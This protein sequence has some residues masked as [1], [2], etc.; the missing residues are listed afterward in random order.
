MPRRRSRPF[1][2][3]AAPRLG[4]SLLLLLACLSISAPASAQCIANPEE[5]Y[6]PP[7]TAGEN[8]Y[9]IV[10]D[11]ALDHLAGIDGAEF[12]YATTIA[13]DTWNEQ[14]KAGWF[15]LVGLSLQEDPL[16]VSVACPGRPNIVRAIAEAEE[17]E[18]GVTA[19]AYPRWWDGDKYTRWEIVIFTDWLNPTTLQV[20]PKVRHAGEASTGSLDVVSELIHEFGHALWL[21]HLRGGRPRPSSACRAARQEPASQT[22]PAAHSRSRRQRFG[23][24]DC[25]GVRRHLAYIGSTWRSMKGVNSVG[26]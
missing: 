4:V 8:E 11:A 21:G 6:R 1:T 14:A 18:P 17:G 10:D 3:F 20:E 19:Y 22:D 24:T 2:A 13:A 7:S 23:R 26:F 9:V 16:P 5:Y 12:I 25:S 15:R